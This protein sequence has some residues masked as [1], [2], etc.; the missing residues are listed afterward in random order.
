MPRRRSPFQ[1]QA[2]GS[3][4]GFAAILSSDWAALLAATH[5]GGS[6]NE[7]VEGIAVDRLGNVYVG[8]E[9]DSTTLPGQT[10]STFQGATDVWVAKFSS[11]L[12]QSPTL[13]YLGGERRDAQRS[14]WIDTEGNL[15][16]TG[17]TDFVAFF[18]GTGDVYVA[19]VVMP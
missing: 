10:T 5:I 13:E 16:S 14:L 4:D 2:G 12:Q 19:R 17:W 1:R 9:T 18:D 3:V 15:I 11:P 7:L 6:G 8:G